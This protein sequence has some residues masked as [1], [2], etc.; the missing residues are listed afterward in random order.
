MLETKYVAGQHHSAA[1]FGDIPVTINQTWLEAKLTNIHYF[2]KNII[3]F[4]NEFLK[5][6]VRFVP[7][8]QYKHELKFKL[9]SLP[10]CLPRSLS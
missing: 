7:F 2:P 6:T 3:Q 1:V 4:H 8:Q 5:M 10:K 9:K